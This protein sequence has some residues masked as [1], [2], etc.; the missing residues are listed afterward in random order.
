MAI[1]AVPVDQRVIDIDSR[2]FASVEKALVELITNCDDS[3]SRLEANGAEVTGAIRVKYERHQAGALLVVTD[4]AEGMSFERVCAILAYGGAHSPLS[5]GEAGGRGYFGRGLKQAIFGLGHGWIETIHAGRYSRIDLFR[6]ES[7]SYLYEDG[8]G[9]RPAETVDYARLGVPG[10]GTQVTIVIENPHVNISQY[11]SVVQ[12]VTD[13]IYLREV[14]RR[15]HLDMLHIQQ[16]KETE[17]RG[18]L[19]YEEPPSLLLL[20]PGQ[21]GSFVYQGEEF[22]FGLTLKRAQEAELTLKGDERTNGLVVIS[23]TAVLDCQLFEYENQVGTEYLFGTINCPAL[24]EKLGQ[25]MAIISDEREGLNRKDT[26][27]EAFSH[28][29][30]RM[31]EPYVQA[32][33]EKLKHLERAT[34]SGRTGHMIEHLLLFMSQAAVRDL[35]IRV[36][37]APASLDSLGEP[38]RPAPMRFTTPFYYRR[39]DSLFQVALLLDLNQFF[40]DEVLTINYELSPTLLIDSMPE[41]IPVSS[42]GGSGRIE[43]TVLGGT[44]GDH[45][46]IS[47]R[48]GNYWAWCEIAMAK[49]ASRHT[50]GYASPLSKPRQPRDHGVDMFVGY[51]FRNLHNE[52]ERAVYSPAERKIIIN[53]GAPTVQLYVD[54]RGHFRDSARLLL[55]ELFM[56][57]ISDELARITVDRSSAKGNA[58]AYHNAKQDII[59][60]Y[61]S[62]IHLSFLGG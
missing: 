45:G 43:W 47:V 14:L 61:G 18:P 52:L 58:R 22:P 44:A 38:E 49:D 40:G 48:A 10:N 17:R 15:R 4:Q 24:A 41:S 28:A 37:P 11:R 20:G 7:G 35:G 59:C 6:S 56:D 30:S 26:F 29:V 8:G 50:K 9:S 27:V 34:T 23:G 36:P 19:R 25:G 51:E 39:C 21:G 54:G 42:L 1:A 31:I 32:E 60:R 16:G 2:R 53:T 46:K 5:R 55:A 12:A 33:Q 13:N 3:Y 57:V 62:E